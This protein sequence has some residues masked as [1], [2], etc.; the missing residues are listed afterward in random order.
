MM[1]HG[2]EIMKTHYTAY[3]SANIYLSLKNTNF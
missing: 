3:S 2:F 1:A